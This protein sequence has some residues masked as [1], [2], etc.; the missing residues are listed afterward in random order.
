MTMSTKTIKIVYW[1]LLILFCAFHVM[2]AAGGLMKVKAG[3]DAM[4]QM[5]YPVYLM[6]FLSVLKLLGVIAL[7]Q[8]KFKTMK[9]WAFAGFAFSLVGAA[10]SHASIHDQVAF[11]IMPLVFLVILFTLYYFWRRLEV[12]KDKRAAGVLGIELSVESK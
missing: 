10:Y 6:T 11:I 8:D 2:D 5:G 7:L 9:E 12:I 1:V 4:N 3:V